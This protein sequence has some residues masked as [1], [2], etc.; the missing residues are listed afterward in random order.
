MGLVPETP[1]GRAFRDLAGIAHQRLAALADEIHFA[2]MGV[3]LRLRPP[4]V[5]IMPG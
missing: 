2:T 3:V 1:L 5:A 4:P